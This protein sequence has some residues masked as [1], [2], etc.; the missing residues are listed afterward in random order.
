L[1]KSA[2]SAFLALL[3]L[4]ASLTP[5]RAQPAAA[6]DPA[7]YGKPFKGV[8]EARN[9][10]IY[11]VNMRGFSKEGTFRAVTARLDSIK[12]LGVDVVYLMPIFPIGKL[13]AVDSPFA[14]QNYTDINPE[15]GTLTDL[16]AL[17]DGAHARKMAVILDWVGNHTSWDHPWV[18][19]HP[20]WYVHDASGAIVNPIPDWKDIAQLDFT[21][22][23][24]RAEMIKALRYWVFQANIDG[25]RFDYADG[26]TPEFFAEAL[27]SL[28]GIR[29]HKLLF[30]AEGDKKKYYL[31]S[32]F[33]LCYDFGFMNVL[34]HDVFAKGKSVKLIDS[35]N[36]ANYRNAAPDARML[37]Y[38]S[39]HDVNSW[40]GTPQQL[41]GGERGAMAAFVVAA[42]MKAVPMIYNGQEVGHAE[43][44]PFMGP[45]RPIDWTPKPALTKEYKQLIRF[46]NSSEALRNGALASYSTDD[47]CA[48]TKTIGKEQVWVVVNLRNTPASYP[49]PAG[50]AATGWHNAFDGK[51]MAVAEP[52]KLQP[53]QYL[54][55]KK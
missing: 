16:R 50:L 52:L 6:P 34:S 35:V 33:Q 55:L 51:A 15:F 53:Y 22:P 24:L 27:Q 2:Y 14:V 3:A 48:F 19:A 10:T 9:A 54:V 49:R 5:S 41:F 37:R 44:V 45:R 31:Q 47:V 7:Q 1:R 18:A 23:A 39:N 40:E 4:C 21:Q 25:Y 28:N 43:R 30:L 42:Y 32:G 12:A 13:R 38:T 26:P 46:R 11:Q 29:T 36:T 17:I 8:P 20:D